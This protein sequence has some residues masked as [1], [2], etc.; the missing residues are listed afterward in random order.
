LRFG[1]PPADAAGVIIA[2]NS[3]TIS[4]PERRPCRCPVQAVCPPTAPRRPSGVQE[5]RRPTCQRP[6]RRCP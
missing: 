4:R 2:P 3:V 6:W 5:L 1:C